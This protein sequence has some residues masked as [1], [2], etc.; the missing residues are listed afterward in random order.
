MKSEEGIL[1][2]FLVAFLFFVARMLYSFIHAH[3]GINDNSSSLESNDSYFGSLKK[4]NIIFFGAGVLMGLSK[5][6]SVITHG[7]VRFIYSDSGEELL[8]AVVS[9]AVEWIG[10]AVTV[11]AAV[12]IGVTLYFISTLKDEVKMKYEEA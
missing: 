7:S 5:L 10:L 4:K 1:F 3:T 12:Y 9:P 6:I 2:I 11:C 8:N